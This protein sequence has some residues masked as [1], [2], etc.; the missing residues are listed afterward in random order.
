MGWVNRCWTWVHLALKWLFKKIKYSFFDKSLFFLIMLTTMWKSSLNHLEYS[1]NVCVV[2]KSLLATKLYVTN[3]T[4]VHVLNGGYFCRHPAMQCL[5][6]KNV[7]K[8][9]VFFISESEWWINE[10]T[11]CMH[12]EWTEKTHSSEKRCNAY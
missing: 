5:N 1:D 6:V 9:L 8:F 2:N 11:N 4:A 12:I 7:M 3:A 10:N